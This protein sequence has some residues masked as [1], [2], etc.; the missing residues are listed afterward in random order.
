MMFV[1]LIETELHLK[2][3]KEFQFNPNR[4]WKADYYIPELNLLIEQEGGIFTRQA[5]GSIAGIL[6]D[7]EKYNSATRLGYRIL[8]FTPDQL[9]TEETL[10]AIREI[11][12][13]ILK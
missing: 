6:R 2:V 10:N 12:K 5:H 7:I 13:L 9:Y 3:I 8:R 4:K 11:A 1:K